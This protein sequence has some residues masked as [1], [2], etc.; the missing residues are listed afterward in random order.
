[1]AYGPSTT[2]S[3][4]EDFGTIES[5]IDQRKLELWRSI[6]GPPATPGEVPSGILVALMMEA[7]IKAI[8]PRPPGNVHAG[9]KLAFTGHRVSEGAVL[10]VGLTC[11]GKRF[12]KERRWL[13][14]GVSVHEGDALVMA[15]E[16]STI[17]AA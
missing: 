16:I 2:S 11:L 9:Q 4:A 12:H 5:R 15:G 7:Y 1:M 14:F 13:T 3:R 17:W 10:T 8:Q 6:Y